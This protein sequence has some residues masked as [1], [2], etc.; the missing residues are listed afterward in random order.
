MIKFIGLKIFDNRVSI[1]Y[2]EKNIKVEC[3]LNGSIVKFG[4]FFIIL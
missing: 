2:D 1:K 4:Y 3:W